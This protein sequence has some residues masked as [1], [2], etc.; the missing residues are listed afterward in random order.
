M[1]IVP[2]ITLA[3]AIALAF[4]AR[5][6][7]RQYGAPKFVRFM[8]W[9]FLASWLIGTIGA[10]VG[11]VQTFGAVSGES[12]DPSQKARILAEGISEAINMLA[13]SVVVILIGA[14]TM[15]LLT[16]RYHWAAKPEDPGG[17]PPYR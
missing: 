3:A 7:G 16:W 14:V 13:F 5:W 8:P 12:V 1:I 2:L 4:W 15:L 10:G 17:T 6:L 9:A 11:F